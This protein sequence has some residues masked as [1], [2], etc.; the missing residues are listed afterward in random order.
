MITKIHGHSLLLFFF[1][2]LLPFCSAKTTYKYDAIGRL[3]QSK[4]ADGTIINYTYDAA[5]NRLVQTTTTTALKSQTIGAFS[6]I[7][8]QTFRLTTLAIAAPTAS[9]GF[10]VVL[11]VKSGPATISGNVLTF[12]G[13]GAITL[14]ADQPGD[15]VYSAAPT[16]TTS[17]TVQKGS[18]TIV[19]FP[20]ISPKTLGASPFTISP[21]V[22][23][24]GLPVTITVKSGPATIFG[25]TVTLT[26]EGTVVL[27]ANQAGSANYNAASPVSTSFSVTKT[28]GSQAQTIS[29]FATI[30]TKTFGDPPFIITFPV[31]SSGLPVIVTIRSGHATISDRTITLTGFGSITLA[32]NQPGNAVYGAAPEMRTTFVVRRAQTIKPFAKITSQ[33]ASV[34]LMVTAP[35]ATSGLPVTLSVR[36]GPALISG[37]RVTFTGTGSVVL[38][39]NQAGDDAYGPAPEIATSFNVTLGTQAI[40]FPTLGTVTYG[41]TVA[42]LA[43]ASSGL[44]VTFSVLSGAATISGRNV[45]FTGVGTVK[46][47]AIQAGN[48]IFAAK[49]VAI[50]VS[51]RAAPQTI[52]PFEAIPILPYPL[53]FD[54]KPPIATSGLPVIVIVKSGPA[55]ISKTTITL[56]GVGT[57]VL[58]ANQA[59]NAN[60]LAAPTIT[61]SFLVKLG[62]TINFSALGTK[63]VGQTVTLTATASSGLPVTFSVLSGS[64]TIAG[65]KVTFT[66]A[67]TVKLGANQSGN[68]TY[69]AKQVAINVLV[70]Q[71]AQTITFPAISNQKVGTV[72]TLNARASSGLPVT[73][74][75]SGSSPATIAGNKLTI[76][77]V[78]TVAVGAHQAGNAAYSAA[79]LVTQKFTVN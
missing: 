24:S 65:N 3:S 33:V 23:T 2:G 9:S 25:N 20:T 29:R 26:G 43:T 42:L 78:G 12:T 15:A 13:V 22:T 48:A 79:P 55:T 8:S 77:G 6:P 5:G 27:E 10:P 64:A 46:L 70:Q 28:Q 74:S 45:T 66:G 37:N 63:K 47:A 61:T 19:D 72:L 44:P 59:G 30:P 69:A 14:A 56:T 54:L 16:V 73:Y 75:V 36:S 58:A 18:Q 60:Y 67:G 52:A 11:T 41:Q 34:P 62:Q 57:V 17:F 40:T 50:N 53:T 21:P 32:A 4:Q 49:Q 51:V 71:T 31:A 38:A 35:I 7:E 68:A 1:L 76:T 39:A